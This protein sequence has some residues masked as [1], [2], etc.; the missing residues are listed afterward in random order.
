MTQV[1]ILSAKVRRNEQ[2]WHILDI[3]R[4]FGPNFGFKN[5]QRFQFEE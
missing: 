4:M 5:L 2:L 1:L 3:G